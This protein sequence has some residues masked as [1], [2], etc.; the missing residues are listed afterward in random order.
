MTAEERLPLIEAIGSEREAAQHSYSQS[1]RSSAGIFFLCIAVFSVAA[2][3]FFRGVT[4]K[5]T[6]WSGGVGSAGGSIQ[7]ATQLSERKPPPSAVE[8]PEEE[9]GFST[10]APGVWG[11]LIW[12]FD[13]V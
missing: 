8:I 2:V 12:V 1:R 13:G 5:K 4:E 6:V 10:Q 7:A 3:T 11:G 9:G